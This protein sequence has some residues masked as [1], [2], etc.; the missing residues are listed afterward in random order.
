MLDMQIAG[1]NAAQSHPHNRIPRIEDDRLG[2]IQKG[3]F[4][5]FDVS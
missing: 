4:S 5:V 2:L 1:A 3:E